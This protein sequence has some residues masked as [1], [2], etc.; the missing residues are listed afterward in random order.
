MRKILLII[1]ML[2]AVSPVM[3]DV[4]ITAVSEGTHLTTG[5]PG[6]VNRSATIR[7]GYTGST[8]VRAFALDLHVDNGCTIG[9]IRDFNVGENNYPNKPNGYGVFPGKFRQFINPSNPFWTDS[10][11]NPLPPSG[12]PGTTGTGLNTSTIIVEMAY[13]GATDSNMPA[14]SGTLFRVDVN[15]YTFAGTATLTISADTMRGGVVGVDTNPAATNLPF[16]VDLGYGCPCI[17]VPY[18]APCTN[19]SDANDTIIAAGYTVGTITYEVNCACAYGTVLRVTTT[20]YLP[21]GS[22]VDYVASNGV[23]VPIE[24]NEPLPVAESVWIG[25]GFVLIGTPVVDCA[26]V[27]VIISQDTCVAYGSPVHFTYGIAAT[28]PCEVN[29]PLPDANNAINAVTGLFVG[30]ITYTCSNTVP[31]NYVISQ[32]PP[33]GTLYC[34]GVDIV[35]S[36]GPCDCFPSSDPAYNDWVAFGKPACWCYLRQCHGDADGLTQGNTKSGLYYVGTNDLNVLVGAWQ[37]LEPPKGP[38]IATITVNGIPGICADF[39]HDA[40]GNTKTGIY[41]VGTNDLNKM[42]TYWQ[43]LEPPKGP[44]TPVCT[45]N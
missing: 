3:A 4:T 45:G 29:E 1:A 36:T 16:T 18:I 42:I 20:G 37:V 6:D 39:A 19:M 43:V 2:L 23:S 21:F 10:N 32:N 27:G 8:H 12:D 5:L 9:N 28:V 13:M 26:H 33:C 11:Y 44:G 34:G 25:Q 24:V 31:K 40:Q 38:G 17:G 7:V 35:V 30:T 41:R 15:A 22:P 14:T